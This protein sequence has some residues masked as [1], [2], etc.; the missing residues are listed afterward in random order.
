MSLTGRN[1]LSLKKKDVL[2]QKQA[3]SAY[4]KLVF[5][6]KAAAGETGINIGSLVQPSEMASLG[7]VNPNYSEIQAAKILFFK[8]NVTITS[9]AKGKL[10]QDLSYTIPT[11]ERIDF[12]GFTAEDGEIFVVEIET[13]VKDGLQVVD[14]NRIVA[15]GVLPAN[16]TTINVGQ[17]FAVGKYPSQQVGAVTVFID[18]AQQFRNTGNSDTNLDAN[19][20]E[21]DAGAGLGSLIEMNTP[22]PINDRSYLVLGEQTA[23]RPAGSTMAVVETLAGQVDAM[24]PTLAALAGVPTTTFQTA[25]NNV[26]LKN[27]ADFVLNLIPAGTIQAYG[28]NTAPQGYLI[29]DGSE[30]SR[31]TYSRLFANVGTN[32]G[33]GDGSTT[34][35]LPDLRG[36]FLRGNINIPQVTGS[37]TASSNAATFTAHGINRTGMPVRMVSGTLSG[38]NTTTTYYAI[39]VDANTLAFATTHANAL[40]NTRIAITGANSAVIRQWVSPDAAGR[41]ALQSGGST[42]PNVGSQEEWAVGVHNHRFASG[43]AG[44][45]LNAVGGVSVS[46]GTSVSSYNE[47][48]A[49]TNLGR[50]TRSNNVSVNYIIKT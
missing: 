47:D 44:G 28:G 12:Q 5:A 14:S 13:S 17:V 32:F 11:N 33:A 19:Y 41:F 27:F 18:G 6:H 24:I 9:S 40:S 15:T 50:E 45:F 26:D 8:K 7:F 38:L 34:F 37:G 3:G 2:Q 4:K 25:P 39:V 29:C 21:V 42:G 31:T 46:G 36:Q 23:E 35:N 48:V 22:D 16:Q 1:T 20:Y 30:I 49:S 10:I 43:N